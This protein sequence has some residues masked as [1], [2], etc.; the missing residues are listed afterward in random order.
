VATRLSALWA[1][2]PLATQSILGRLPVGTPQAGVVGEIVVRFQER[3]DWCSRL[4]AAGQEIYDLVLG[5]AGDQT[6]MIARLEEAT[7]R[8]RAT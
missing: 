8:L 2:V 3:A 7:R 6:C 1:A 5:L 4:E